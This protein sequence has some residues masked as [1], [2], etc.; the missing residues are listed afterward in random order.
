MV[1]AQ[2]RVTC[3][4][5]T[6]PLRGWLAL[7]SNGTAASAPAS[8]LSCRRGD[9]PSCA[10]APPLV[11]Q[12]EAPPLLPQALARRAPPSGRAALR[13]ADVLLATSDNVGH[14]LFALVE[15]AA[16]QILLARRL[17]LEPYVWLGARTFR[18]L[19]GCG[20]GAQ[21]YFDA[22]RGANVWDYFFEQPTAW[23][24]GAPRVGGRRVRSVQVVSPEQLFYGA[25]GT[26]AQTYVG[27]AAYDGARMLARRRAAHAVFAN[28]SLV[29]PPLLE[30]ARRVFARWR[31]RS[32]HILGAHVRGTDKVVSKKV[33]PEAY[34]PFIDGWLA[35]HA[36]GLV[37]V[38]TDEAAYLK[39]FTKRYG[40]DRIV[41]AQGGYETDDPI[42]D[43]SLLGRSGEEAIIDALLLS[44]CDF[45][46]KARS[47]L[48]EFAIWVNLRLHWAHVD[49]QWE[50]RFASQ[51]DLPAWAATAL[52]DDATPYCRALAAGCRADAV[53]AG[54]H[55]A[56]V[57]R[58][59]LRHGQA[60][61][62]C[63]PR[64]LPASR[65][66]A[67]RARA[68][69]DG[70]SCAGAGLRPLTQPECVALAKRDRLGFIGVQ[71]EPS[72]FPGC[73]RWRRADVEFNDVPTRD[74]RATCALGKQRGECLCTEV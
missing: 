19:G 63:Q 73:V 4:A 38:A 10:G 60:C 32:A 13:A 1:C 41:Y 53:E 9:F 31:A 24:P 30:R 37:V 8:R 26:Y 65:R 33:P 21:P 7:A 56:H 54:A 45:L 51:P 44:Q 27:G 64:V 5:G 20:G 42:H 3:L 58:P 11:E 70:E 62:R 22:R 48:A 68:V 23:R 35:A 72:E 71:R 74:G 39:R 25:E 28:G 69:A 47:A 43:A 34:F 2:Y 67:K 57:G 40:A 46:L 6:D 15:R 50:D 52:R 66:A 14:G 29:R 49:L 12:C 36:D 55:N 18:P 17:G 59:M 16:N 61:A